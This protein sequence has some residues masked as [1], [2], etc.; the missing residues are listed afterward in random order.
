MHRTLQFHLIALFILILFF[1]PSHAS[2]WSQLVQDDT[3]KAIE[4]T[5]PP[6]IDGSEQDACWDNAAW[7]SIDQVWIPYGAHMDSTD[8]YGEYKVCWSSETSRIYFLVKVTDDVLVKGY[9]FPDGGW[10]QWDVVEI[11]FDEDKSGG[12]H[13]HNNNAFA[14]HITAGNAS[15]PY[16][17]IDL[18]HGWDAHNFADHMDVS[19]RRKNGYIFW[20]IGMLVYDETFE[21]G[22][23]NTPLELTTGKVSGL[24][25]AYCDNDDPGEQPKTRDN[26]IGSVHVP[27][28]NYN[29]HWKNA[30]FFGTVKLVSP[31]SADIA[32]TDI[33]R[34][35][36]PVLH[37][38]V[39]NPFNPS[40][41]I[42]YELPSHTRV[43][44]S[45][46]N[47]LSQKVT[48]L[49]DA[50]QSPGLHQVHWNGIDNNGKS[51]ANGVYF[52]QL[53]T[54][55][56]EVIQTKQMLLVR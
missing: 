19:I 7:Q 49:V 27:E 10:H 50:A 32:S 51:V 26:F 23:D 4:S 22:Q 12:D 46:L 36:V 45:V 3:V 54:K 40:T 38:N 35:L 24:S 44:L 2:P 16:H 6:D 8:F 52:I 9:T 55:K 21:E 33:Q 5:T 25:I 29:D 31:G 43:T 20:E 30:D 1:I 37:Q 11:F 56:P 48:T 47:S 39:P 18:Q 14:Y 41:A 17:A 53:I 42:T 15:V 34:P 13:T 28:A